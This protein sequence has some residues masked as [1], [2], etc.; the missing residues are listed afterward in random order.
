M[1]WSQTNNQFIVKN[2]VLLVACL[3]KFIGFVHT[4]KIGNNY[5]IVNGTGPTLTSKGYPL[6]KCHLVI[7]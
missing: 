5:T 6:G 2:T 4:S 3:V 1:W 7:L